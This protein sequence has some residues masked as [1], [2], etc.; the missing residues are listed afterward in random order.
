MTSTWIWLKGCKILN[1]KGI[2]LCLWDQWKPLRKCSLNKDLKVEQEVAR[3]KGTQRVF[4]VEFSK[5][6]VWRLAS[7]CNPPFFFYCCSVLFCFRILA[8]WSHG[9]LF[10][11]LVLSGKVGWGRGFTGPKRNRNLEPMTVF[12]LWT[13]LPRTRESCAV[14]CW[15]NGKAALVEQRAWRNRQCWEIVGA[16][17]QVWDE[18]GGGQMMQGLALLVKDFEMNLKGSYLKA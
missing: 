10:L 7:L 11:S 3:H 9:S 8:A 13:P 15:G 12:L 18:T 4:Q 2:L 14:E 5:K 6:H 16:E 1:S 17:Q